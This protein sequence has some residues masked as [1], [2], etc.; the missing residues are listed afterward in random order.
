VSARLPPLHPLPPGSMVAGPR[1]SSFVG[2]LL[3]W[4]ATPLLFLWLA[5]VAMTY[6]MLNAS[7]N[8]SF[9]QRLGNLAQAVGARVV[10]TGDTRR[11]VDIAQSAVDLL[12]ADRQD[13]VHYAVRRAGGEWLAGDPDVPPVPGA[14]ARSGPTLHSGVLGD[15]LVRV[16]SISVPDPSRPGERVV[17]QVSETLNKRQQFATSLHAQALLPQLFV[18]FG[19]VALVWYGAVYVVA[20]MRQIKSQIDVRAP[21]DLAPLPEGAAPRELAP[22]IASINSLMA[23]LAASLDSQQRFV[24]D[25]AHQLRT[26]LAALKSQ[27]ELAIAERDPVVL[28]RT[29]LQ[30]EAATERTAHLANRLLV[31]A[32]AGA[33]HRPATD[34]DLA[35]IAGEAVADA[36][37]RAVER[38]ID[39]GLERDGDRAAVVTGD[40]LMLRELCANLIDNAITYTPQGGTVTVHVSA[41]PMPSLSV[42]DSGCGIAPS[43]RE[44]VL[45]PFYR[46]GDNEHPGTGLG[47]A[48]VDEIARNHH[49]SVAIDDGP[50]GTGTTVRVA[51][52]PI[53]AA[54]RL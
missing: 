23:R 50:N 15:E 9:D 37:P 54:G 29:L 48:I 18:L 19:A 33:A 34:V 51:F 26:P 52:P 25:A 36:V 32:R 44:R 28:R 14:M 24:A 7:A 53:S 8:E 4:L 30:L 10:A 12:A 41:V 1:P 35:S 21:G 5:V 49:A 16:A 2:R 43:E 27:T 39:L 13:E 6:V 20:P 17:V 31:L 22:L 45:Q 11:P 40:P 42:I 46:A 3:E 38:R 47:L